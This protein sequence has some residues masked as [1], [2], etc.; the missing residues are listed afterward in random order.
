MPRLADHDQRR[1]QITD[2]TRRVVAREGLGAATF[3]S[4]AAE[5]G[6][7]VRL[8]QYYFGTKR[9]FLLATHQAV[10]ADAG[11]RF[12][13]RLEALGGDP[14]PRDVIQAILVE[15]LPTDAE[16]RQDTVVL[17]AFHTAALTASDVVAE[18]TLG[19]P[20][21][22]VTAIADQLRRAGAGA[23]ASAGGAQS[24]G[25]PAD[26]AA[27]SATNGAADSAADLDAELI[28]AAASGLAQTLLIDASAASRADALLD[29]LLDRLVGP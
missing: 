5:A 11:A 7:S 24:A 15:L 6:I 18:D 16:R 8:V 2:A 19:A 4:V 23:A 20:R 3:Q 25:S 12:T 29:R 13:R 17:N 10:V 27:G 1:T 9:K 26:D 21:Y 28:V 22:L 14:A